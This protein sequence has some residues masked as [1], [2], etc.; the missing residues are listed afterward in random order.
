[1]ATTAIIPIHASGRTI[2]KALKKSVGYIENPVKTDSGEWVS[3]YECDPLIDDKEFLF[4]K[5]QYATIIGR[6]QGKNDVLAYHLRI[7][8][9][10]GETD[11]TTANK[12]GYDLAMKLTKGQHS[13]VCCTHTDRHHL[14]SHIIFNSTNLDCTRKFR[15]FKSSTFV[16]RKMAD[17]LCLENGLSVVK[18]P[19][20]SRDS[21]AASI[22]LCI[23]ITS[24]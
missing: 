20:P 7:S 21:A 4:S 10:S 15:N 3:A 24:L 12:I 23:K 22:P 14:H 5:N 11:A 2:A 1:M 16:V 17:L 8:F 6:S 9:K 18:N 19:K 13:F